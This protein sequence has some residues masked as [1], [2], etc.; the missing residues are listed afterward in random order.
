M[1]Q[2]GQIVIPAEIRK[3]A[4]LNTAEKFFVTHHKGQII[5]KKIDEERISKELIENISKSNEEIKRG[6]YIELD[7]NMSAEQMHAI[8]MKEDANNIKQRVQKKAKKGKK[9][10]PRV[11]NT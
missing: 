7:S 10:K 6:E 8:L 11:K 4:N 5:L 1:S 3:E 9:S 2:N